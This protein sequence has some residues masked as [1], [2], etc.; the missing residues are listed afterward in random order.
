MFLKIKDYYRN[1]LFSEDIHCKCMNKK[2]LE[3]GL[4]I[5]YRFSL[6][7]YNDNYFFETVNK[8]IRQGKCSNCGREFEFRWTMDG[9]YFRWLDQKEALITDY[10]NVKSKSKYGDDLI[11]LAPNYIVKIIR[12]NKN[13]YRCEVDHY[14]LADKETNN[15]Y[16]DS[17]DWIHQFTVPKDKVILNPNSLRMLLNWDERRKL[18]DEKYTKEYT[19]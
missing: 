14:K 19:I 2:Y 11:S 5:N 17:K 6:S 10:V 18:F 3:D 15:K 4:K 8:N 16:S 9:I 13:S 1:D 7:G 12:E